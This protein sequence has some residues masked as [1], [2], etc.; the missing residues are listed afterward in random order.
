MNKL[1]KSLTINAMFSGISGIILI[2]WNRQIASLFGTP[3][4]TVFCVVG[5]ALIAFSITIIYEIVKQRPLAVLWIIIQDFL[6]VIGSAILLVINPFEISKTGNSTI[7][8]VAFIVLFMG[9]NQSKAIAQIDTK[10]QKWFKQIVVKREVAAPKDSVWKVMSDVGNFHK[11]APN[12]VDVKILSGNSEGLV[13][14]CSHNDKESWTETC[15]SWKPG[16]EYSFEVNTS[17]PDYPYPLKYLKGTFKAT[18]L[19]DSTT[20]ITMIY[21]FALKRKIQ[22]IF[23]Y[24][25]MK[26]QFS[27]TLKGIMDNWQNLIEKGVFT[28]K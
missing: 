2:T 20:E 17:A 28:K 15:T 13:R 3:N 27:K 4:N 24:P 5:I 22:N 14:T 1:Q 25:I 21:D 23:L 18:M 6:W 26:P 11:V 16:E 9:I 12:L 8:I 10:N 7:A 19:T